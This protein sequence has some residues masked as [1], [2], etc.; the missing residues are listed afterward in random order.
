MILVQKKDSKDF[1][2]R[3]RQNVVFE[4]GYLIGKLGREKVCALKKDDVETP[5][6]ISGIVYTPMDNNQ[7]WKISVAKEMKKV[8]YNID[9]NKIL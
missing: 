4:H 8:G 3:A 9:F 1:K 5:N 6:D 7:A 2:P